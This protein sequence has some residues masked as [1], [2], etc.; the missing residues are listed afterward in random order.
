LVTREQHSKADILFAALTLALF[1]LGVLYFQHR[2][3]LGE[4]DLYRVLV[5]MLD[6]AF[7]GA[8]LASNLH[9]G[10]DFGFGYILL[11]Y[12]L[13]PAGVLRDPDRLISVINNLGFCFTV[14]GLLLFWLSTSMIHGPRTAM[15]AL[16]LLAFSPVV[17]ELATSGHQILIAFG[18]LFASATCLFLPV[19]GWRAVLAGVA[20]SILLITGLCM[21]AEIFLALPFIVLARIRLDSWWAFAKSLFFN[22][23]SPTASFVVF[24]FLKHHIV[25]SIADNGP[26]FFEQF[27]RWSNILPGTVYMSLGGGIATVSAGIAVI[28]AIIKKMS[29][30]DLNNTKRVLEQIL[31][32][33]ALIMVPFVFWI[34][35]PQPSRHFLLT[36]AGISILIGW[37]VSR[38]T[39]ASFLPAALCVLGLI[40]ANQVLSEFVRRPLLS[41]NAAR[42]PY[43]RPPELH[44]T[45]THAPLGWIWQHH[46]ALDS[47]LHSFR[48]LG[49]L[50]S[51]SCDADTLILS[52]ESEQL[53]SRLYD[54][55]TAV[56][57]SSDRINGFL[58]YRAT[59]GNK[60]FVFIIK[61]S[62]WPHDAVAMVLNEP[63]LGSYTIYADPYLPSNYDKEAIPPTRLANFGCKRA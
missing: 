52:D 7:T 28:F 3:V 6:G 57:A 10:K 37:A 50:L 61:M 29:S 43:T 31:G 2:G 40:V 59:A 51:T 62:G 21:R 38:L 46:A 34:A 24:L 17:L 16:A 30:G 44:D 58:A 45:F 8:G 32:P 5:G 48:D 35:N 25:P 18:F 27:Y 60:H 39:R 26:S 19:T 54:G 14:A 15:V 20:G 33:I 49:Q 12:A 36:I 56:K 55:G 42:S 4:S 23:I 11:L 22:A 63:S 9:Y 47:R 41:M 13:A 53:L 1:G